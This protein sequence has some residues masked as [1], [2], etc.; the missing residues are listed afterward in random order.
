MGYTPYY[1]VDYE[2]GTGLEQ[3]HEPFLVPDKA[4]PVLEDA[5]V[6]RGRVVKRYGYSFLGRLRRF[7][8]KQAM[9]NIA[10]GA[11]PFPTTVVVNIFTG[12]GLLPTEPRAELQPGTVVVPLVISIAGGTL[13]TD[14]L[15]DGTTTVVGPAPI[16]S[17]TINYTNGELTLIFTGAFA[18][19]A[20]TFSGWYFPLLPVM[21]LSR[22]ETDLIN[23][24]NFIAFDQK[25][26]YSYNGLL[27]EELSS[28]TPTTWTGNDSAFFWSTNY[29][30][31]VTVSPNQKIFWA[32]NFNIATPDPIRYYNMVTWVN[33]TPFLSAGAAIPRQLTTCRILIAYKGRFIAMNT[34]ERNAGG[35]SSVNYQNRIRFSQSGTPLTQGTIGPG[36][37]FAWTTVSAWADDRPGYG[38]YIDLPTSEQIITAEFIKDILL[39]KCERSSYKIFYTGIASTPFIYEKINTEL[40]AESTFSIVPFDNGVLTVG[41][42]GI[43]VD[44]SVSVVRIDSRIPDITF[45]IR[46]SNNGVKRVHGIRDFF[47]E[48]ALWTYPGLLSSTFPDKVLIYNYKNQSFAIFNDS[49]TCFGYYQQSTNLV[50]ADY[51]NFSWSQW[52]DT[53]NSGKSQA[54]FPDIICGNQH[55]YVSIWNRQ[56][57]NGI[58]LSLKAI[59][60]TLNPTQFTIP[61][62]NLVDDSFI[63]LTGILASAGATN[64]TNLNDVIFR[65]TV[66]DGDTV[67]LEYLDPADSVIKNVNVGATGLYVGGGKITVLNNMKISTKLFAPFYEQGGQARLGY[68]DFLLDNTSDGEIISNVFIDE[69]TSVS[70]TDTST[71][72]GTLGSYIVKTRP[73]NNTLILFQAG[74]DK[75]WHRQYVQAICQNFQI[76]LTLSD[77][78][79][80][81]ETVATSGF[82]LH[83]LVLYVSKNARLVQ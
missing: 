59:N 28:T 19:A 67:T 45:S 34:Y 41:N 69:C 72:T 83:A 81:N 64:L 57:S 65:V 48:I 3:Y 40:G 63:K 10:S 51:T 16:S 55:G 24:E 56:G 70:L 15:G 68:V 32:T 50:W 82:V 20:T 71:T 12:L 11:G 31:D 49:F 30:T 78:Q 54:Q 22:Q 5:F 66:I 37:G 74:Q 29:W 58:S 17:A 79:M 77:A 44:D 25:Y 47:L 27:F 26:S 80:F 39:V 21:A 46:N 36:P 6:W 7:L 62:H 13:I 14:T 75:I 43:T 42:Y 61:D 8:N 4:F 2:E 1:I 52:L 33:F 73:E 53:W 38:G 23:E 60:G 76:N 18:P 9:G 35:A